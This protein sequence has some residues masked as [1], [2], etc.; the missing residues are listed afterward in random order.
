MSVAVC[1]TLRVILKIGL[2]SRLGDFGNGRFAAALRLLRG[3]MVLGQSCFQ[4]L[5]TFFRRIGHLEQFEVPRRDRAGVDHGFEVDDL[6]PVSARSEERRVGKE[7]RS[8][9]AP[10]P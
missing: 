10:Y 7:G 4:E 8:R 9:W 3:E 2:R 5:E 6:L 1:R